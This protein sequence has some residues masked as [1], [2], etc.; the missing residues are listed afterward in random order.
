[1]GHAGKARRFGSRRVCVEGR[2]GDAL[3]VGT[4]HVGD[5][6]VF[7]TFTLHRHRSDGHTGQR[8]A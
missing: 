1:M 7:E 8:L 4:G 6:S 2:T 5:L 3:M